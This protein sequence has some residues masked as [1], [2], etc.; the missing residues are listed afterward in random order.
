MKKAL[1]FVVALVAA[2]SVWAQWEPDVRLTNDPAGSF[3]HFNFGHCVA[4]NGETVHIVWRDNRNMDLEI[5]Y[6]RST[7]EGVTWG[8]DTRLTIFPGDSRYPTIAVSGSTVHIA[9]S[10]NRDGNQEIYYKHSTDEGLNWDSAIRLTNAPGISWI[11]SMSVLGSNVHIVWQDERDGNWEIYYKR[12]TDGGLSWEPDTRLTNNSAM[13]LYS[14]ISVS[15]PIVHVVWEDLRDGNIEIYYKRST[16]GGSTW[17]ADTRL[18]NDTAASVL[19]SIASSDSVVHVAWS[20]KRDDG[21]REIYYNRSLDGGFTWGDD[22][23]LTI[24]PGE[25]KYPNIALSGSAVHIVWFDNRDGDYEIYYKRSEDAGLTWGGD[26]RLTN[27]SGDS[28]NPGV[29]VSGPVVHVVWFDLRDGNEE[30]YYKRNPTGGFPVGIENE[31]PGNSGQAFSIY[32]N[33]A[34]SIIH[35]KFEDILTGQ[36]L[37]TIRNIL[38][39]VVTKRLIQTNESVVDVS[40]LP[41]GLYFIEIMTPDTQAE[42]RKLVIRN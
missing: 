15:G 29:A 23:R 6:K 19:P 20:D 8:E 25:S 22:T 3:T 35:I 38:G 17:E 12:S 36:S 28:E 7:D 41:D 10:D 33:P 30:I 39:E 11:N 27:S 13:S 34:S 32:P 16:D 31:L 37:L 24:I 26:I 18:T 2:N 14:S 1:L 21:D 42:I 40:I 4:V 9:W 5:Y